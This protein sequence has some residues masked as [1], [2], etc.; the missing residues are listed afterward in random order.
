MPLRAATASLAA[1]L[2]RDVDETVT[3]RCA[4]RRITGEKSADDDA[5]SI[6]QLGQFL[7]G[8]ALRQI[9]HE[10]VAAKFLLSHARQ[11]F[12]S[13]AGAVGAGRLHSPKLLHRTT[14]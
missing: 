1:R 9:G 6:E 10:D 12:V 7:V 11:T 3:L 2:G 14:S 13:C 5:E 8:I 4:G